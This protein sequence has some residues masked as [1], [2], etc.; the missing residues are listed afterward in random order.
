MLQGLSDVRDGEHHSYAQHSVFLLRSG[1]VFCDPT[2]EYFF[3][4]TLLFTSG[5]LD[6][7]HNCLVFIEVNK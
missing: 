7:D 4:E 2:H 1:A 6:K 3:G 5:G